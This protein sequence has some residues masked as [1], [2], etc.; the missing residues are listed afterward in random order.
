MYKSFNR[1]QQLYSV[2]KALEFHWGFADD[3]GAVTG[4]QS[5]RQPL[6]HALKLT[7]VQ[8]VSSH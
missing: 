5:V 2:I 6:V 7:G 8:Q 3:C 4:A 1:S